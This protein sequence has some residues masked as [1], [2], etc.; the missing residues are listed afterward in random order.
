MLRALCPWLSMTSL[1]VSTATG[2][3]CMVVRPL[4]FPWSGPSD[5]TTASARHG[6]S[7]RRASFATVTSTGSR[8]MNS[9]SA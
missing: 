5:R 7:T 6:T 3:G 9:P 8:V 2:A 1:N 4:P